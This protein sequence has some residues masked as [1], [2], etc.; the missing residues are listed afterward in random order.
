MT[1]LQTHVPT[2]SSVL[3]VLITIFVIAQRAQNGR[4]KNAVLIL[5][6]PQLTRAALTEPVRMLHV[7]AIP[8]LPLQVFKP[9]TGTDQRVLTKIFAPL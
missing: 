6:A 7:R 4:V 8:L 2:I 1:V 5:F 3:M 9:T